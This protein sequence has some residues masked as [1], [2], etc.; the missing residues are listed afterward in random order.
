MVPTIETIE[1]LLTGLVGRDTKAS[2]AN[3]P[4]LGS[5]TIGVACYRL[6]DGAVAAVAICDLP[7][8]ARFG[9]CLS[10]LP[11]GTAEEILETGE[12]TEMAAENAQEVFNVLSVALAGAESA[13]I[14]MTGVHFGDAALE[15]DLQSVVDQPASAFSAKVEVEGYGAGG[16]AVFL[17]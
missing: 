4:K 14:R 10:L 11:P 13:H 1:E 8:A 12:L 16:L 17:A 7:F 5:E 15:S 3:A 6:D 9:A 2:E